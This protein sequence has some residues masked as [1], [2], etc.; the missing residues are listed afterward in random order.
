MSRLDCASSSNICLIIFPLFPFK[1]T[2]QKKSSNVIKGGLLR[3]PNNSAKKDDAVLRVTVD[4]HGMIELRNYG[5]S[6]VVGISYGNL[7]N[8]PATNYSDFTPA[9][10]QRITL[11]P[12]F[13]YLNYYR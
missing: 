2:L 7:A 6:G 3:L 11:H 4:Q 1:I 10:A 5:K 12:A 9:E 8:N 13:R